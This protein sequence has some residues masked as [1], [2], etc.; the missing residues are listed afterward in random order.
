MVN[1]AERTVTLNDEVLLVCGIANPAPLKNYLVQHAKTYAELSF[2]DHHIFTIDD[3]KEIIKK[4]NDINAEQ[5]MIIT[6]EKDAVRLMKFN[7]RVNRTA[8]ICIAGST[9]IFV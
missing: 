6:T 8:F 9:Q 7:E 3:L 1:K 2:S 5:K 4:F